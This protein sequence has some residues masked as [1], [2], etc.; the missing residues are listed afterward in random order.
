MNAVAELNEAV[1]KFVLELYD[2]GRFEALNHMGICKDDIE[3]LKEL[4][5]GSMRNMRNYPTLIV[6]FK[7]D[8]SRAIH[9]VK[10]IKTE[11]EN[12][13]KVNALIGLGASQPMLEDLSGIDREE[14]K[15]RKAQLGITEDSRG[16]PPALDDEEV[17]RVNEIMRLNKGLDQIGL[18]ILIGNETGI[19]LSSV[20]AYNQSMDR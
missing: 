8:K 18:Y 12:K 15:K 1:I 2:N 9:L 11:A 10:H 7:F 3:S 19:N 13:S 6:D 4:N 5:I 16:R 14:F 20:W 17:N